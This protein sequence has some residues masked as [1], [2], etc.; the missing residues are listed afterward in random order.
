MFSY[1]F[2]KCS[3]FSDLTFLCMLENFANEGTV[4]FSERVLRDLGKR[5]A[6]LEMAVSNS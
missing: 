1:N 5:K 3:F 2:Y 4:K 6:K